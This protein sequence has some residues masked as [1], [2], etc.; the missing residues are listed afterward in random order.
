MNKINVS[1]NTVAIY[2]FTKEEQSH[3]SHVSLLLEGIIHTMAKFDSNPLQDPSVVACD[4]SALEIAR[5]RKLINQMATGEIA[6]EKN[7]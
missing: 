1:K 5:V 2:Q 4:V 7:F 6:I 3:L